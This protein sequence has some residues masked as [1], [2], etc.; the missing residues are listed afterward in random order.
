MADNVDIT[1]GAALPLATDE[2]GGRHYQ[3]VKVTGGADGSEN[4]AAACARTARRR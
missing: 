4:H 2:I 1:P 3:R